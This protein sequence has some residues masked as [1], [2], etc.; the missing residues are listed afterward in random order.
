MTP[1]STHAPRSLRFVTKS[2]RRVSGEG[3]TRCST[4]HDTPIS[5]SPSALRYLDRRPRILSDASW[6][7]TEGKRHSR[8]NVRCRPTPTLEEELCFPPLAPN[9]SGI[10]CTSITTPVASAGHRAT[11]ACRVL[12]AFRAA[13]AN[14][15]MQFRKF[16][17]YAPPSGTIASRAF[18][19]SACSSEDRGALRSNARTR[20]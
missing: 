17:T 1:F 15:G 13:V 4:G 12:G 5:L 7:G 20:G 14:L 6:I 8:G 9:R 16:A 18:L 10:A 11:R 19:S 3:F 2:G